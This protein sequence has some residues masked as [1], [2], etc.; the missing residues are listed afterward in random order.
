MFLSK[1]RDWPVLNIVSYTLT[2]VTTGA[3]AAASYQ[4]HVAVSFDEVCPF[5]CSAGC[6]LRPA[7][8]QALAAPAGPRLSRDPLDRASLLLRRVPADPDCPLGGVAHVPGRSRRDRCV[9]SLRGVTWARLTICVATVVPLLLWSD[10]RVDGTWTRAGLTAWAAVYA[11]NLAA[12][13]K[14]TLKDGNAFA[15]RDITLLHLNSLGAYTG[16]YLLMTP[17]TRPRRRRSPPRS[18][19]GTAASPPRCSSDT[20]KN[21]CISRPSRSPC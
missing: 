12:L 14:A 10:P 5:R 4:T 16:A 13:L 15:R 7:K 8:A 11:L 18:P 2:L 19:C 6:P 20:A 21:R 9:P 17:A 1:R 3:W